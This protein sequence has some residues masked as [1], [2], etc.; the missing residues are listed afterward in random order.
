[1]PGSCR[2]PGIHLVKTAGNA[3]DGAVYTAA[4]TI[5]E[6]VVYTFVA[7]NTGQ[8]TLSAVTVS[9]PLPGLSAITCAGGT[10][11]SIVLAP[12]AS[13]TC[14][15][16][17]HLTQADIDAGERLNLAF[18]KGEQPGGNPNDPSD[19]VVHS[20]PAVVDVPQLPAIKIVKSTNGVD[21][22]SAPGVLIAVGGAVTWTYVVTNPGTVA[23]GDV[24][25]VDDAGTPANTA[26]DFSP[27]YVSGDTDLDARLDIGE[28]WTYSSAGIARA[29]QYKNIAK[30]I[31]NPVSDSGADLPGVTSP[32]DDDDDFYFGV[33]AKINVEKTVSLGAGQACP[34]SEL[35]G[36][37]HGVAVTYCFVITNTGNTTLASVSMND[38][39]L[40]ITLANTT[41]VG[42]V[43]P[44][45]GV[46]TLAA[47]QSST[48]RIN[49][50]INGDLVNTASV[51]GTPID[52]ITNPNSPTPIPPAIVPPPTDQDTAEVRQTKLA[53]LGDFVWSDTNGD[54][55]QG[56]GEPGIAGVTVTL[57]PGTPAN[58]AD[59]LTTTTDTNGAY[60]FTGLVPGTFNVTFTTPTGFVPSPA[61]N[62]GDDTKDS[63]PVAGVVTVTLAAGETNLTV[64]AG[65]QPRVADL[66]LIKAVNV[67]TAEIGTNVVFTV[68]VTNVGP[69]DTTGVTVTDLLP[70]GLTFVSASGSGTYDAA[71]GIWTIGG[72]AVNKSATLTMVVRVDAEATLTN[73]A[74]VATSDLPDPDSTPGNDVPTEDDQEQRS[75]L[76]YTEDRQPNRRLHQLSRSRRPVATPKHRSGSES[77][78]CSQASAWPPPPHA[79]D[80]RRRPPHELTQPPTCLRNGRSKC[81]RHFERPFRVQPSS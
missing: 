65:F 79:A 3:A 20:D 70:A 69:F 7:T 76:R 48:F 47:G 30:V 74:Q 43:A 45:A 11:G 58:P 36:G 21:H 14:T 37:L 57:D 26:D 13:I 75:R 8:S 62:A 15:A 67:A 42:G 61:N 50:T 41:H 81:L 28:T 60:Q 31:G 10:N 2:L 25:V 40:G 23:L 49:S 5:G 12:S 73:I 52:T 17:Y 78:W 68:Y 51:T 32:T 59:D 64:D 38:T 24:V 56:P 6:P 77:G 66:E 39:A 18:V 22:Q 4:G 72:I 71:T 80:A 16:T 44:F 55:V 63:D 29:G 34:G 9:D 53:N 1:M 46:L 35:V 27:A 33:D 54:G 19:D